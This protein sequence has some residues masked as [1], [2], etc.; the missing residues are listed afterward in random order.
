MTPLNLA[1]LNLILSSPHAGSEIPN[2][3]PDRT[4]GGCRHNSTNAC[5][6]HYNDTCA[7]DVRC[8]V[9]TVQDFA[10]YDPL[11]ELLAKELYETYNVLPFVVVGNWN[12]KKI[13]FNREIVEA[14]FQHP[15][16]IKAYHGYH[17][18]IERA[19]KKINKNFNGKGLLIDLHQHAQGRYTMVGMRLSGVQ[20]NTNNLSCTSIERLI[21]LSCPDNRSECI[22]GS[23]ALGTFLE[24]NGL[25]TAYPSLN[26]P[27]PENKTFYRGGYITNRYSSKINVIQT[28][29]SFVVRNEFE[30][31]IE[32]F[33]TKE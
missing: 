5:T 9:T 15:N 13:D 20:L 18:Y 31:K 24:S 26:N 30:P 33:V 23:K 32:S 6:F 27:K 22:F 25:G 29:L 21:E 3:I 7:D 8:P 28:E 4:P 11:A 1:N 19:V 14:T 12:R 10:S 17:G 16:A 2:G